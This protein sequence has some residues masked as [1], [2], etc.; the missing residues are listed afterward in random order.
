MRYQFYIFT[1]FLFLSVN[2]ALAIGVGDKLPILTIEESGALIINQDGDL[3]YEAWST[4]T[5]KGKKHIIQYLPG[6]FFEGKQNLF[7]N[8]TLYNLD[9][10]LY[11]RIT[12]IVNYSDAIWG[13]QLFIESPMKKNKHVTPLCN[14]VLDKTG[15]GLALWN[16][17]EKQ[18]TTIVINEQGIIEFFHQGKLSKKQAAQ[19]IHLSNPDGFN[20]IPSTLHTKS[21]FQ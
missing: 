9:H 5:L 2:N 14:I 1:V 13:T 10:P 6:R 17:E 7:L 11:C 20:K 8:E 18:N 16:L 19:V 12:T 4:S 3:E 15:V 21:P